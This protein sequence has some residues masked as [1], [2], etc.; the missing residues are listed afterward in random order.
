M[1]KKYLLSNWNIYLIMNRETEKAQNITFGN[2]LK[3]KELIRKSN[4]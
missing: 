3:E 4:Y 1:Y 2:F